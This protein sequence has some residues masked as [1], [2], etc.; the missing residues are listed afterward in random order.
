MVL[1]PSGDVR[2]VDSQRFCEIALPKINPEKQLFNCFGCKAKGDVLSFLRL[3][4]GLAF[5]QALARLREVA[6]L[7]GATDAPVHDRRDPD[8]F[9]GGLTRPQ[10]LERV[11]EHYQKHLLENEEARAYL[12]ERG[13]ADPEPGRLLGLATATAHCCATQTTLAPGPRQG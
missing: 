8:R 3:R 11:T 4:E 2:L 1:L 10:L 12:E 7:S 13:L 9:D 6:G 5:P